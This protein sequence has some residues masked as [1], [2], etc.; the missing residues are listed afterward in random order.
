MKN[1]IFCRKMARADS[2][3][4]NNIEKVDV[5]LIVGSTTAVSHPVLAARIKRR[6]R[7]H[8]KRLIVSDLREHEMAQR[9][10]HFI[11]PSP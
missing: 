3:I 1:A 9:A 4:M 8:G 10:T 6:A 5:V 7:L 11:R 2:G